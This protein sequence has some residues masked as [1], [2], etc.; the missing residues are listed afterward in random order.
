METV[1]A[2][3]PRAARGFRLSAAALDKLSQDAQSRGMTTSQY[4]EALIMR[5]SL[6]HTDYF[7]QQAAVNSFI[8]VGLSASIAAKVLG[9]AETRALQEKGATLAAQMFGEP[10]VRPG[11][12][13]ETPDGFEDPRVLALFEAFCPR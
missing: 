6:A 7:A 12:I 13:G 1:Q 3:R 8:T 9:V 10:R 4:L 11:A 2:K 5:T